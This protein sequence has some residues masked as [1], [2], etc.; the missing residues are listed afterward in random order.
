MIKKN[1]LLCFRL[2]IG[3]LL[4]AGS[5]CIAQP[6]SAGTELQKVATQDSAKT[7]CSKEKIVMPSTID[8]DRRGFRDYLELMTT[9]EHKRAAEFSKLTPE[10][11]ALVMRFHLALQIAK[12]ELSIEQRLLLLRTIGSASSEMYSGN[13]STEAKAR[14]KALQ[15]SASALFSQRE[16]YDI[17]SSISGKLEDVSFIR[18]YEELL[19]TSIANRKLRFIDSSPHE[20]RDML[21][22]QAVYFL[23]TSEISNEQGLVYVR[24]IDAM[25]P[26]ALEGPFKETILI[27]QDAARLF[28]LKT[29][30]EAVFSK[31]ETFLYF[32][33][34]GAHKV[35]VDTETKATES[36]D[37]A[38]GSCLCNYMCAPCF[39]CVYP[40][41][42]CTATKVGCGF[43]LLD[44]CDSRC[45][46]NSSYCF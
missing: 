9:P 42:G 23:A 34:L 11:A 43:I 33:S 19:E 3:I 15:R 38:A 28:E 16:I 20:R 31:S 25:T 6:P 13:A 26:N 21:L 17:F 1:N 27:N 29:A 41:G 10:V 18:Q 40:S 32:S 12:R 5:V 7:G 36:S 14:S 37:A 8:K 4:I 22:A 45:R 2:Q 24:V 35:D 39:E 46:F 44:P 30:V